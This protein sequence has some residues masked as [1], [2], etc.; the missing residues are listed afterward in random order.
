MRLGL[1]LCGLL[2]ALSTACAPQLARSARVNIPYTVGT[3]TAAA[4]GT[5][6]FVEFGHTVHLVTAGHVCEMA[7][8]AGSTEM[9]LSFVV[10][11]RL[12][13][14]TDK[15]TV[16]VK[17]ISATH[18][19]C[20]LGFVGPAVPMEVLSLAAAF[21]PWGAPLTIEGAPYGVAVLRTHATFGGHYVLH[22]LNFGL[23][24]GLAAGGN[25]GS[26]I[27]NGEGKV[28]GVLVMGMNFINLFVTHKQLASFLAG[29][30]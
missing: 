8:A 20:E 2:L 26:P 17:R 3:R 10:D 19:L 11:R 29:G 13:V 16:K 9:S 25:S 24:A 28:Q 18:D 5:A 12:T 30:D 14:T 21:P 27:L 6:F 4:A 15:G 23:A 1:L 22:G 7:L